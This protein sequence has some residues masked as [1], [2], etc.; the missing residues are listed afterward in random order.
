MIGK[1][2]EM[3]E[4][5]RRERESDQDLARIPR[6]EWSDPQFERWL[7]RY[8][9]LPP[10]ARP[11]MVDLRLIRSEIMDR[12]EAAVRLIVRRNR[13]AS[14]HG[15]DDPRTV[16]AE[17]ATEAAKQEMHAL[18]IDLHERS[19]RFLCEFGK[20]EES[21]NALSALMGARATALES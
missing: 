1:L 21:L 17:K 9:A 18:E 19:Y 13:L 15:K 7:E 8:Q 16:A 14:K 2:K 4:A 6:R 11:T 12:R 5:Y 3:A 10:A 20:A